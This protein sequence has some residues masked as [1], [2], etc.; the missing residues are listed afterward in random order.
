MQGIS[1]CNQ[2]YETMKPCTWQQ[3]MQPR[4]R[5]NEKSKLQQSIHD[6]IHCNQDHKIVKTLHGNSQWNQE[7]RTIGQHGQ[8]NGHWYLEQETIQR[9]HENTLCNQN[10]KQ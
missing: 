4:T 10:M 5:N 1:Y 6:N 3:S 2:E 7:H 9:L 8:G